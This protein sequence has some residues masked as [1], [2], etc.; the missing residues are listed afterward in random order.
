[1]YFT[2]YVYK[3]VQ[4]ED[5]LGCDVMIGPYMYHGQRFIHLR[6]G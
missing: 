2:L 4:L 3:Y 6:G 5:C 1:M